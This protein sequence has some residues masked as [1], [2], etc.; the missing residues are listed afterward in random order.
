VVE[1]QVKYEGESIKIGGKD[2]VLP[3]LSVGQSRKLIPKL[4]QKKDND[5]VADQMSLFVEIVQSALSRNYP[6][7]TA[8]LIEEGL[9]PG[10]LAGLVGYVS[11]ISGLKPK[12]ETPA[13][14]TA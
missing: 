2:Y 7:I 8:E 6:S 9:T 12:G 3:G 10:E 14:A 5:T 11:R 13:A 4:E 1:N